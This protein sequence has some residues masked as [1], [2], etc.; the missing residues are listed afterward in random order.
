[1]AAPRADRHGGA[2]NKRVLLPLLALLAFVGWSIWLVGGDSYFGFLYLARDEPWAAQ[3]LTDL[4]VACF[5]VSSWMIR[6]ARIHRLPV[7]PYL[8]ATLF[9]GS[10]GPLAYLVHRG[11]RG[12]TPAPA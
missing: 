12:P 9:L 10:I 8:I 6:D 1:M 4:A 2:M 7:A 11:V 3:M 5:L